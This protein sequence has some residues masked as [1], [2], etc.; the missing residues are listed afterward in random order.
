MAEG[1]Q[2]YHNDPKRVEEQAIREE[3]Q[4][5]RIRDKVPEDVKLSH[6]QVQEA[7]YN[8]YKA[9]KLIMGTQE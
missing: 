4:L 7:A 1:Y 9:K 5:I 3:M 6:A 2:M 8:V